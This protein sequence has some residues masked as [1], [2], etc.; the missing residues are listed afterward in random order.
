MN[1]SLATEFHNRTEFLSYRYR[2]AYTSNP[3]LIAKYNFTDTIVKFQLPILQNKIESPA[4]AFEINKTMP[5]MR[6]IFEAN[7]HGLVGNR[8]EENF[9]EFKYPLVIAYYY[10]DF[11][12]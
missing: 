2:F 10:I 6:T 12:E 7:Y 8:L 11:I 3:D 1:S 9:H 5:V 4:I